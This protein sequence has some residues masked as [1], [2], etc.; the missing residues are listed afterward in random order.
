M[1]YGSFRHVLQA[2]IEA[3]KEEFSNVSM[4]NGSGEFNQQLNEFDKIK[5]DLSVCSV[6]IQHGETYSISGYYIKD[7][8]SDF[9]VRQ[10]VLTIAQSTNT[11]SHVLGVHRDDNRI[12]ITIPEEA[13]LKRIDL[14]TTVAT[15]NLENIDAQR[16]RII[17]QTGDL[18]IS[19]MTSDYAM[20]RVEAG[21]IELE[22]MDFQ[23][24][25]V[26]SGV[27]EVHLSTPLNL[28]DYKVSVSTDVGIV[29]YG[30][31]EFRNSYEE[32]ND[33]GKVLEINN[34]TGDILV[35]YKSK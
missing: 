19:G 27:S 6:T 5:A 25:H 35:S 21:N 34:G 32:E 1:L 8:K 20:L 24:L 29:N 26:R 7:M 15:I 3:N 30:G 31:D 9:S 4:E 2:R 11:E 33:T 10:K 17:N 16:C 18:F 12:V 23:R 22:Q 28:A 14:N 13:S